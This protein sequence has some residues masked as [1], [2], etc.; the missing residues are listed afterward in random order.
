MKV[1]V[2]IPTYNRG[3]IIN[4]ALESVFNQTYRD[5]EI[6]LVDD[7]STDDTFEVVKRF[8]SD[9]IRY[10]RHEKNRRYSAACNTGVS[11]A[12][13]QLVA[14]L[15]SDDLWKENYLERQTSLLLRCPELG[16]TFTDTEIRGENLHIK[17]LISQMGAFSKLLNPNREA[18]EYVFG[19]RDVYLCLLE[20]IPIKPSALVAKRE[21][22]ERLGGFDET[23]PSG[24]DW[25]L[26]LRFS[27]SASFGYI[28]SPLVVQRR[29]G[30]A[31]HQL[32][33][34]QDKL[35]LLDVFRKE[36]AKISND[37]EALRAINRGIS[38]HCCNLGYYYL[39]SGAQRKSVATYLRGF[40]ETQD[41][42]MLARAVYAS[43]PMWLRNSARSHILT[44]LGR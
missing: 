20:E 32:Y 43:M 17:S 4:E 30:D 13:G 37:N 31:T 15:D 42:M 3:Y 12:T 6:V 19:A 26:L 8:A 2:V 44:A 9:K 36:K 29:T 21:L 5:F 14:F 22:F 10:I 41:P 11:A 33:L 34:E 18:K 38:S 28:D 35:F 25:D 24:T 1:S 27:H 16:A 39:R 23:W 7:C 40:R